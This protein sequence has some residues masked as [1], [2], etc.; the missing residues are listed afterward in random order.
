M[1]FLDEIQ[2]GKFSYFTP[3]LEYATSGKKKEDYLATLNEE[4]KKQFEEE[5]EKLEAQIT[6]RMEYVE[7]NF[8]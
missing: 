2:D 1:I 5:R 8:E 6:L 7:K 3:F 4:Q